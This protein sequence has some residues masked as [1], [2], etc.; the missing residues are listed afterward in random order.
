M[1]NRITVEHKGIVYEAISH[2]PNELKVCEKCALY[3]ECFWDLPCLCSELVGLH[4]YFKEINHVQNNI[5]SRSA[6]HE[7]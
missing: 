1:K 2:Q 3:D 7:R 5:Q 6:D 4:Y